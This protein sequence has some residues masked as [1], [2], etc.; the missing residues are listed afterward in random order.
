MPVGT[1]PGDVDAPVAGWYL[2]CVDE[3]PVG[4][5]DTNSEITTGQRLEG[6]RT[7][8]QGAGNVRVLLPGARRAEHVAAVVCVER[9]YIGPLQVDRDAV[10]LDLDPLV[11]EPRLTVITVLVGPR[12]ATD[13]APEWTMLIKIAARKG[14]VEEV[15]LTG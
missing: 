9:P 6:Q 1:G 3:A 15:V 2:V 14:E 13:V 8:V 4:L 12:G 7:D 5:D 10:T 11:L